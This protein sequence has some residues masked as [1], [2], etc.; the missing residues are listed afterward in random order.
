MKG[1]ITIAVKVMVLMIARILGIC[2][3]MAGCTI[4]PQNM[5]TL[6]R[7]PFDLKVLARAK[8]SEAFNHCCVAQH[9]MPR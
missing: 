1:A 7:M 8:N 3:V 6:K 2:F 9:S 4:K 5:N